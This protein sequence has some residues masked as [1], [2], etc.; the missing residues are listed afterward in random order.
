[1][2]GQIPG[3]DGARGFTAGDRG[4][5]PMRARGRICV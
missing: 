1:V 5:R 4:G 3:G 2:A